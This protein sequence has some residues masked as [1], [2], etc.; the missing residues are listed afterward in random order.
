MVMRAVLVA[1]LSASLLALAA[2]NDRPASSAE[3]QRDINAAA[4][5]TKD[6]AVSAGHKA[7]DL[8]DKARDNTRD[9][10]KSPKVQQ[11]MANAKEAVK[12]AL[13]GPKSP[14]PQ[15]PVRK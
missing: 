9:F 5:K 13:D 2:C 12:G 10:F 14:P 3:A 8:A 4:E 15:D 1:A 7:A 11:D 6:A